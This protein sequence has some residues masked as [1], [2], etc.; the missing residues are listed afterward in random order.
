VNIVEA[1]TANPVS[2]VATTI[3]GTFVGGILI[4]EYKRRRKSTDQT[5]EWY[6]EAVGM[7]GRLQQAGQ[8]ITMFT[9]QI[10]EAT[11]KTKFE[12]LAAELQ[13]HAGN[14][15][16]GV[17]D[18][19]RVELIYLSTITSAIISLADRSEDESI[20]TLF[21][22]AQELAHENSD[23]DLDLAELNDLFEPASLGSPEEQLTEAD[24]NEQ[25]AREFVSSLSEESQ[26]AG[27]IVTT[28]DVLE[29]PTE[30]LGEA[31]ADDQFWD[32]FVDDMIQLYIEVLLLDISEDIYESMEERK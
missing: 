28:E 6:A 5:K 3:F 8:Q 1:I 2:S 30:K 4:F 14:A 27:E 16:A 17:E 26:Q 9:Q 13:S 7:I 21:Q 18:Q 25:P 20:S 12:P 29:M 19:A 22:E 10:N 11:L 23:I 32:Q 15:P 24:I 31:I